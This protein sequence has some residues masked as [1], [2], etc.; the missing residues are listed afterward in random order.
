MTKV[1]QPGAISLDADV[2]VVGAGPTGMNLALWLERLGARV[3]IVDRLASPLTSSR[4]IGV[5]ARTLELYRQ[6]GFADEIV[7]A[8]HRVPAFNMW[9]D[10]VRRARVPFDTLGDDLTRFPFLLDY[11]QDEHERLLRKRLLERGIEIER[12]VEFISST[13]NDLGVV[14]LLRD[15]DGREQ[16]CSAAY[17]AGCDGARSKVRE[18][19]GIGFAGGTYDSFFYVADVEADGPTMDGEVH[20]HLGAAADFLAVFPL[21]GGR[22]AR[23]V[24]TVRDPSEAS[25][26]TLT[27]EDVSATAFKALAIKPGNVNW[28]ST[29]RVHHRV[30]DRFREG[31]AFLLGDAGH[32]HSP[33]GGQGMNTGIGDAVNLAW[34]LAAVIRGEASDRLLDTF[35]A[36]RIGFARRLVSTT[37]RIFSLAT[38]RGW[39]ARQWRTRAAPLLL[40]AMGRLPTV[41]RLNFRTV[42]QLSLNYRS[43]P[44]SSGRAGRLRG[45]DRLPWVLAGGRDNHDPLA[46]LCWQVHVYGRPDRSLSTWCSEDGVP[47]HAFEWAPEHEHAGLSENA[48]YLIRPDGHVAVASD[49]SGAVAMFR[50][51]ALAWAI[52]PL[53]AGR[54]AATIAGGT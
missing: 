21:D 14:A 8:G 22:R 48:A 39:L 15:Q 34:K 20:I 23:L 1:G 43:S 7:A 10:G 13:E 26:E 9:V 37:D 33:V 2:L 29:Y 41:G 4:A 54:N 31:R 45:G 11:G 44:L 12:G 51:F 42:S 38:S 27:F 40:S 50:A 52:T 47:V 25:R 35:E 28:F 49:A 6:L 18:T 24:G 32:V 16:T 46:A 30:A 19:L 5:Q 36:E 3:R 17:L 53:A